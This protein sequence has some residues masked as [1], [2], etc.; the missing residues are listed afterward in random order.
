MVVGAGLLL[1]GSLA[2]QT[3]STGSLTGR[4]TDLHSVSV[5][6]A[7]ITLRNQQTGTEI[8]SLTTG[9]GAYRFTGLVPGTYVL[10]ASSPQLG[11]GV[12]SDIVISSGHE[13]R[14]QAALIFAPALSEARRVVTTA[15]A[16]AASMSSIAASRLPFIATRTLGS[17][18][19]TES[20]P[21]LM[22]LLNPTPMGNLVLGPGIPLEL[23]PPIKPDHSVLSPTS[24]FPVGIE[25][26]IALGMVGAALLAQSWHEHPRIETEHSASET[27][28][29]GN[30]LQSLPLAD[31]RWEELALDRLTGPTADNDDAETPS[32][33]LPA[34]RTSGSVVR[35][36]LPATDSAN[37]ARDIETTSDIAVGEI[38]SVNDTD[39]SNADLGSPFEVESQRGSVSILHGQAFAFGR[40]NPWSA[41]N[42]FTRWIKEATTGSNTTVPVFTATPYSPG[43]HRITW[44]VGAGGA[45]KYAHAFWFAAFD[46]EQR[47][48]PAVSTVKHPENFFAQPANDEMQVLAARLSL[49]GSNPV[50][51]GIKAYSQLLETLA[52]LLGP[53][54]RSSSLSSDFARMDFHAGE[55]HR[56][57]FDG[58]GMQWSSP[59]GGLTRTSLSTASHSL[60]NPSAAANR[61]GV[62]WDVFL[63]ESLLATTSAGFHAYDYRPLA[64]T[65]SGYEDSLIAN[66]WGQVPQ[67]VVDNRYGM[68]MGKLA[69]FGSG[70]SPQ[71]QSID[72]EE[73]V[74]WIRGKLLLKSGF[75]W[76]SDH[77]G[78]SLLRNQTG[79]YVYSRLEN[80]AS[81]A[82]AFAKFGMTNALD[83][84][85]QHNCDQRGRAW[86]DSAGQLHGLGYLPCYSYYTQMLG[87]TDWHVTTNDF[88]AWNTAQWQPASSLVLST[89]MRWDRQQLPSPIAMVN[90]P[91]LPLTQKLPMPGN[92]WSGRASL[93][94]GVHESHW[95]MLRLGYG[96][97]FGRT[98]NSVLMTA[99]TQTGSPKGDMRFF[100]RPMDNLLDDGAPPFPYAYATQPS[101]AVKSGAV[102]FGTGFRNIE[103]HQGELSLEETLPGRMLIRVAA[104]LSLGR[105]LPITQDVN[106]DAANPGTITYAVVDPSHKGPIKESQITVPFFASWPTTAA[107]R[108]RAMAN[109]QNIAQITSRANSTYEALQ[110]QLSRSGNKGLMFHAR[111]TYGH[112]WDWNPNETSAITGSSVFDPSNFKLEYGQSDLDM[113]HTASGWVIWEAPWRRKRLGSWWADGWRVSA[114]GR[115]RSGL[116]FTMHTSGAIPEIFTTAGVVIAGLEPGMNG[117]GGENR[118]YGVGRNTYRYP[119]TWK[120]DLRAGRRFALSHARELEMMAESFN[121]FNHQNVT[122]LETVGYT[123]SNPGTPGALPTLNFLT[124]QKTGQTEFGQP[125]DINGTDWYRE[126]HIDFGLRLRF[127]LT[128]ADELD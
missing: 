17:T 13:S 15:A 121:L 35:S 124:G 9:R 7:T 60:G 43:D 94:W 104:Q 41:R 85:N 4:L 1:C 31:R 73:H 78:T 71:E 74:D 125:L 103:V 28:L 19:E 105:R 42:P 98:D 97:Y 18:P 40:Q 55:R 90:N 127:K 38:R 56:F 34:I 95:P 3:A 24:S 47:D 22:V 126:R 108:G 49:S 59:G 111:Y 102:E 100:L 70:E 53:A 116:P 99:L 82:L 30:Q 48:Y 84:L 83:P 21:L 2:G 33:D 51:E 81:D 107:T 23:N 86:R 20:P 26:G 57:S 44:G 115:Y 96:G 75:A 65:P 45:L 118:V 63:A 92:E 29:T 54:A 52:S 27:I 89:A 113:R 6:G 110:A 46:S 62:R 11:R 58:S 76:Q 93:A 12:V 114:V 128:P 120:L 39:A 10:E 122:Q 32:K 36:T 80:F 119:G 88:A 91:E 67:I 25:T 87:P 5:P 68:T 16:S 8:T 64:Q 79:T 50:S 106:I 112:A 117:Y 14:V 123:I 69:R 37:P 77:E 109:Y 61:I 66:L 72:L 101:S